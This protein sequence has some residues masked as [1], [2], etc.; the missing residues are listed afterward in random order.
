MDRSNAFVLVGC[1]GAGKSSLFQ[2]L[3]DKDE[4]AR[5]TQAVVF[6]GDRGV[7]TPG[8]FFSHPRMYTALIQTTADVGT[9]VYV[10]DGTEANFRMP[11]GL[12]SVYRGKR[13]V[14]V[15]TKTDL[16]DCDADRAE[17]LLRRNGFDGQIFRV[18]QADPDSIRRLRSELL[19]STTNV[20][21][22]QS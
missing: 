1:V 12:L 22:T 18:S 13:V 11:P 14:A 8:E 19:P 3:F 21:E 2:A 6:E 5:K 20:R 4:P 15:I 10:H 9:L 17:R 16:P 7:D